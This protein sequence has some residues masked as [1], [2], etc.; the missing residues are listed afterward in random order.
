[1]LVRSGTPP[2][3]MEDLDSLVKNALYLKS[4]SEQEVLPTKVDKKLLLPD[5][6]CAKALALRF[7]QTNELVFKRIFRR[8]LGRRCMEQFFSTEPQ[9]T[10]KP[11]PHLLVQFCKRVESLTEPLSPRAQA[12]G[13][14]MATS[15][16]KGKRG[17]SVRRSTTIV[18]STDM[19]TQVNDI[20]CNFLIHSATMDH[21]T[22]WKSD[23]ML[24]TYQKRFADLEKLGHS[25]DAGL[26]TSLVKS[27][28]APFVAE[29][30]QFLAGQPFQDFL[31]SD[32]FV[33]YCRW[34][35]LELNMSISARDFDIHRI[36]GRGG[37]GEVY[38]ARKR[39]TGA[40]FAM[41]QL[42]KKRLKLKHQERSATEERNILAEL[43]SKFVTNL[44]YAFQDN[45][46]LYLVMDLM[47]GGDLAF[48]L[49]ESKDGK[50]TEEQARFYAGEITLGL[51]HIHSRQMIYRD[52]K[53]ENILL[54]TW[55]HARISDM[56]LVRDCNK[57]WPTSECGTHGYM[58]PEVLTPD[59]LYKMAADWFSL[60]CTIY[61][62]TVGY[63]PF[64]GP[65]KSP[66]PSAKEVDARTLAGKVEFPSTISE[67]AKLCLQGLLS[68]DP[69][70][71]LGAKEDETSDP[72]AVKR[73]PWMVLLDWDAMADHR[74]EPK[75]VPHQ[76]QVNAENILDITTFSQRDVRKI[77]V[78]EEDTKKYYR[79][80]GHIMSHQWQ[81]EVLPM[82]DMITAA[83]ATATEK[84]QRR[85]SSSAS[86][87]S[88][89]D[90]RLEGYMLSKATGLFKSGWS[91][92]YVH[93]FDDRIEVLA[94]QLQ[95]PK[96][97]WHF[98]QIEFQ[99]EV[100]DD[101]TK[102][103]LIT[104]SGKQHRLKPLYPSDTPLWITIID[105]GSH[106]GPQ[107]PQG[108]TNSVFS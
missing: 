30:K 21:S 78:T 108:S 48:H 24:A 23:D 73:H 105:K 40:M 98:N 8:P 26:S 44:K 83:S 7:Q 90:S 94:D 20:Y 106:G 71:R 88:P 80:F 22:L 29:A 38:G 27:L 32:D 61:E 2:P 81:E 42:D 99:T 96:H 39:D 79:N 74:L 68:S 43:N 57:S 72:A 85:I 55:G 13:E 97:V 91:S 25:N 35:Q 36:L 4:L 76:G 95:P 16:P 11:V 17:Q 65:R 46:K 104:D 82:F 15:M 93:V 1:M 107:S 49:R 45:E 33:Q 66:R 34:K 31:K 70:S 89:D 56:G 41:K 19:L 9:A 100:E 87:A 75:I 101:G 53:P 103:F 52:L 47:D 77:K 67:A 62:M 12:L 50:F 58:A 51:E 18:S 59:K 5:P 3:N 84:R 102:I 54:D 28:F 37:F 63:S 86:E 69:K 14:N 92:R 64:V 6:S 10:N 60:G